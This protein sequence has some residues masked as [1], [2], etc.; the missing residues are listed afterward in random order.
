MRLRF[1]LCLA[2]LILQFRL[3]SACVAGVTSPP[4]PT[5]TPQPLI[6]LTV[7]DLQGEPASLSDL[8]GEVVL[9]NFWASWCSPCREEMPLLQTF[10]QAH[11]SKGF[12]LLA[13]NVSEDP[14][15]V[16]AFIEE[17]AYT[18]PVWSDPPEIL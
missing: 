2:T 5:P 1:K 18:F 16:A 8:R 17:Q 13:I 12:T 4:E 11:H 7:K 3:L 15:E 9:V 14:E 10:Y 6:D